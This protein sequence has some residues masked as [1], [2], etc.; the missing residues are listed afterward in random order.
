MQLTI[1]VNKTDSDSRFTR[2][3]KFAT[4][5]Q[6]VLLRF[7]YTEVR[8]DFTVKKHQHHD[9]L[10]TSAI[11]SKRLRL[12]PRER[13]QIVLSVPYIFRIMLCLL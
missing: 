4:F 9:V 5:P 8:D 6:N 1:E 7:A 12:V 10:Q 13:R 2:S 11:A 3:Q